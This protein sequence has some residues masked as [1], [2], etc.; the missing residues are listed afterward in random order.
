MSVTLSKSPGSKLGKIIAV[1]V[2]VIAIAALGSYF[3]AKNTANKKAIDTFS[4]LMDKTVG[5]GDWEVGDISYQLT[6][7]TLVATKL[8]IVLSSFDA[9]ITKPLL[10]DTVEIKNGLEYQELESLL[11]LKDWRSQ[12]DLHLADSV[13]LK[14]VSLNQQS[15]DT[16]FDGK[17]ALFAVDG[18]DLVAAGAD[19][20]P[21]ILGFLKS[22]RLQRVLIE[23]LVATATPT[24]GD[25]GEQFTLSLSKLENA[26]MRIGQNVESLDDVL[27]LVK[28]FSMSSSVQ[29]NMGLTFTTTDEKMEIVVGEQR[30]TG[31][32]SF[33][34]ETINVKDVILN[35]NLMLTDKSKINITSKLDQFNIYDSDF[36]PLIDKFLQSVIE[37]AATVPTNPDNTIEDLINRMYYV[38]DL[39]TLPY[40][41]GRADLTGFTFNID[42][43]ITAAIATIHYTGPAIAGQIAP[44]QRYA[45]DG[46]KLDF[47]NKPPKTAAFNP[48]YDFTR[49]FG[50][51]TFILN[52]DYQSSYDRT[53]GDLSITGSPGFKVEN[54][55]TINGD[56]RLT[57]L[58][59][60]L[61]AQMSET[62]M[63]NF[64]DLLDFPDVY[65]LGITHFRLEI[66]DQ[67][68]L[69]KIIGYYAK[70]KSMDPD[71][72][73][74]LATFGVQT[75]A[76]Y[77]SNRL[78]NSFD[79]A[80]ALTT[81]IETPKSL[82]I[83]I[84][85]SLPLSAR[86][87][88]QAPTT[89]ELFNSLNATITVNGEAPLALKFVEPQATDTDYDDSSEDPD[90]YDF[91]DE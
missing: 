15:D 14:G 5:P 86:N 37:A 45:L 90:V 40:S 12:G 55:I 33:A 59:D 43:Q 4:L 65:D 64:E 89:S 67:S 25:K 71:S 29:N 52:Y 58:T 34:Y 3:Y 68:L 9:E 60:E 57:G 51:S 69:D 26:D 53:A 8:S 28:S 49:D 46:F 19:N 77:V 13:T 72:V 41:I 74:L 47:P 23:N 54:L 11:A 17:I 24:K 73:R 81:F 70:T 38:S 62:L 18:L 39:V 88:D 36:T 84:T 50:Q 21:S 82:T 78:Q 7:D 76:S 2:V 80:N 63:I 1:V 22:G 16:L 10:I 85:P 32:K 31:V 20:S 30:A 87:A 42:D 91:Q 75:A 83:E 35:V 27:A 79:L 61:L 6:D 56:L 66:I 44:S 48:I